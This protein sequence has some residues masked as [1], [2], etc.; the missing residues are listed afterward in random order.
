MK[1]NELKKKVAD[2]HALLKRLTPGQTFAI[3]AQFLL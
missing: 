3:E 2:H 1:L